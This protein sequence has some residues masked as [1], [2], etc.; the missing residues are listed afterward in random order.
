MAIFKRLVPKLK[1]SITF[2]KPRQEA[3]GSI[4]ARTEASRPRRGSEFAR[5]G[6]LASVSG[7]TT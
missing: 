3:S 4:P 5:H 2:D 7:M 1:G 6:L